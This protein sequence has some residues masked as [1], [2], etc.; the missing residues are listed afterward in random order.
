MTTIT[1]Y[2]RQLCGFCGAAK[3]LLTSQNYKYQEVSLD[4]EPELMEQV[5]QKSGQR[6]MPQIFVG[7]HSVGGFRELYKLINDD[8]FDSLVKNEMSSTY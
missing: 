2:T 5:M 1:V 4:D 3:Q 6:T 8:E 7:D